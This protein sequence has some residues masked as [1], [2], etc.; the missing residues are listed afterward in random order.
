MLR[1]STSSVG[2]HILF[3]CL[4]HAQKKVAWW[5]VLD[6]FPRSMMLNWSLKL[7]LVHV[8][9]YLWRSNLASTWP[10]LPVHPGRRLNLK[11]F[12]AKLRSVLA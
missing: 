8:D 12:V 10:V 4:T 11:T 9:A 2:R 1:L 6:L 5:D 3:P 7:A